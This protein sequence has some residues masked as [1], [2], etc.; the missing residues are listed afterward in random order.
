MRHPSMV[1]VIACT[2]FAEVAYRARLLIV[3][4]CSA[5]FLHASTQSSADIL[6]GRQHVDGLEIPAQHPGILDRY[7]FRPPWK[8]AGVDYGVGYP[9]SIKLA[10]PA[11][12]SLTGVSI[13]PTKHTVTIAANDVVIDGYD[14]SLGGGWQVQV[15]FGSNILITNSNFAV[16]SN[17]LVPVRIT[18]TSGHVT[19]NNSVFDG[20]GLPGP[21][22]LVLYNGDSGGVFTIQ[23]SWVKN[24]AADGIW[25][26]GGARLILRGNLFE[27]VGLVP[28]AHADAVQ[29]TQSN[30]SGSQI[31]FNTLLFGQDLAYEGHLPGE[32]IQV[33]SQVNS[34]GIFNIEVGNNTI[35]STRP[36][37]VSS[38]LIALRG[39]PSGSA[40]NVLDGVNCHDNY[41]DRGASYG[42]F[43]P[44]GH[45]SNYRLA[46]NRDMVTGRVIN[47]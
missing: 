38:Y 21:E 22:H 32:G 44:N 4:V 1:F 31:V 18:G 34:V 24:V 23:H 7:S 28:G 30:N 35:V 26:L 5:T 47:K 13:D 11:T 3:I 20:G 8:V 17:R 6:T 36:K 37:R 29:F 45:G 39:S 43:Y 25:F 2:R 27:A 33:E 9:A 15:G 42:F 19:I 41:M 40:S 10:D 12:M 14:F 16:G 46:N